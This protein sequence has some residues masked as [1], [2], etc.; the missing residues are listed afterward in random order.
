M[1][2]GVTFDGL[3]YVEIIKIKVSVHSVDKE[4]INNNDF[5]LF[6]LKK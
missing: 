3:Q 5:L 4:C 2:G 1:K 6:T